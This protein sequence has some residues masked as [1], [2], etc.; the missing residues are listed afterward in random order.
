MDA[1][2][3]DEECPNNMACANKKCV[4]YGSFND[5]T[6]SDNSM[7]CKSGFIKEV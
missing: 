7:A 6:E 5:Y 1:C 2:I 3:R 4:L